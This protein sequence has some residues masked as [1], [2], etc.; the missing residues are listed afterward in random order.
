MNIAT[1]PVVSRDN[2]RDAIL[3]HL[4]YSFG[5]TPET[6]Q[7]QDWRMALS[8]AVRDRMVEAWFDATR[9]TYDAGAKRVYYLSMEFLIGRLLEDGIVNLQ[10]LDQARGALDELG[11]DFTTI[12]GDEPDA[13]LGNGGLGRLAACF[14][15][16]L[17][18]LGCPAMGYGILYEHDL[19]QQSFAEG[20]QMEAPE[21]WLLQRHA[22]EFERP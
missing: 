2:L 19:F 16:S 6:A 10:L 4:A 3:S 21:T 5:K 18:T 20:R 7:T 13:A 14:L 15:E 8:Y 22:R 11:L 17:S 1:L 12:V 9:R